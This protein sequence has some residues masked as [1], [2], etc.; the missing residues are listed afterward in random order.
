MP[1]Q[2]P[3]LPTESSE[4]VPSLQA[5]A[6]EQKPVV[7]KK[8][9]PKHIFIVALGATLA[10]I[11]LR[12][13]WL[14]LFSNSVESSETIAS[15]VKPLEVETTLTEKALTLGVTSLSG[16]VEAVE[17]VTTTSRVMGQ[18][19][20]L[21]VQEGD[22][23]KAGQIIAIIDVKDIQA[24]RNQAAAVISQA[25]AGVTVATAAQTQALASKSQTEAQL[26]QA[27]ARQQEAAAKLQEAQAQ[28]ADAQLNQRRMTMLRKDGAVSQSQLDAA[29]TQV[30]LIQARIQQ[31]KA[32]I[33]QT[34]RGIEQAKAGVKQAVS[35]VQQAKAG[36]EQAVSQVQQAKAGVEQATANLDYGIV[37]A[38]FAGVV[39]KKHTEVGAIAGSG[40]PLVT[41]ES[42]DRLRFSV[43]IPESMMSLV[44]QGDEVEIQLDALNRSVRGHVNQIIP[45]AN[46]NSRSFTVKIALKNARNLMP[47]M[48]G[49][50]QLPDESHSVMMIPQSALLK[51]GQLERVYV[52]GANNIAQLRWVKTG[53]VR[54]SKV[55]IVSGLEQKERIITRNI[56][57]LTDGQHVVL[58]N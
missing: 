30:A 36:V 49:R 22:R 25:Q 46:P 18:I 42:S 57:Q 40:Q 4:L 52:V 51:R 48:F 20:S 54:D 31:V 41:L 1:N 45:S 29:N 21:P 7:A 56:K 38:P 5:E 27:E 3:L 58:S 35:Q 44:K 32:G 39:T 12:V 14:V 10:I 8:K 19:K 53:K 50:M 55:E 47:G 15:T 16:T 17:T 24:Q 26:N 9:L 33:E 23:V 2:E 28:L 37:K 6:S 43:A 34:K 11:G 13:G